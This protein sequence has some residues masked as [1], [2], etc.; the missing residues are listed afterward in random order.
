VQRMSPELA[1]ADPASDWMKHLERAHERV[2]A[3]ARSIEEHI[4]PSAYLEPAAQRL[5]GGLAAMYDAFDGRTDRIT[6]I[7]V[8]HTRFWGAAILVARADLP[9][10]LAALREA[11]AELVSAEERFPRVPLAGR[12]AAEL[13]AGSDLPLLHVVERASLTPSFRAPPVPELELEEEEPVTMLPEPT[14]FEELAAVAEAA[15]RLAEERIAAQK[16]RKAPPEAKQPAPAPTEPPPGFAFAPPAALDEDAFIRRWARECFEE[17]GMLGLQRAP[18]AGDDWRACQVLERRLVTAIDALAALGPTAVAHVE[19]LAMDA[20]VPNPMS[21][22]AIAMIGGS[23]EGRDALACAER[24]LYRFGPN[25]PTVAAP[26]VAAMKLAPNPFVPSLLRSLYASREPGC[27]AIAVEVLAYRGWLTPEELTELADEEDPRVLSL[28]LPAL[29]AAHRR[30]LGRVL[31]RSLALAH[32]DLR[33][34]AAAL[35]AMALAAHPQAASAACAAAHGALGER[36][37]VRLAIVGDEDDARWL[38]ER[39]QASPTPAAV[40]AVGW[41]GLVDAV[42]AL[43]RLLESEE[44]EVKLAAGGALERMLGANLIERIEVLPEALEDVEVTDPDPEPQR[45]R[46][47]LEVLVSDPRHL[48]PAGSS[49]TIEVASTDLAQWRAY[50][51]EHRRRYDPKLRLRRGQ[52]YSPSVSLYELDK[53]PLPPEDR[54]RIHLELAARTG[55]I[56]RFDT[57]DFVIVQ[58]R[59]LTV[60]ESLVR[61]SVETPGSW[62]RT[63]AR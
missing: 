9:S 56:A 1:S 36:A 31:T 46:E 27:R 48:P 12:A 6:A 37:L 63:R 28:A 3:A 15:R 41:A 2:H 52:G 53:L 11:C 44:Q 58:E 59:S 13:Q 7:S 20:P 40:E 34:Q 38:L 42:P 16:Q 57:H 39:M 10:A 60:W 23:L 43:L 22:F 61:T 50:W 24:V 4:E 55:K 32:A 19:R 21:V 54:R 51:D 29:A 26:F 14:T 5:E 17:I 45:P 25:D 62:G 30:D 33:V 35:D 49:E 8:A 47:A 18:L